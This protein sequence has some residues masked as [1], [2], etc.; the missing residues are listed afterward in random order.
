MSVGES[1][2]GTTQRG[3]SLVE[4]ALSIAILSILL[5]ALF[6]MFTQGMYVLS[7]SKEVDLA[8]ERAHDCMETVRALGVGSIVP[9]TY[10]SRNG[11]P[12]ASGFPP[13]PYNPV[14][15]QYP[16]VV[17]ATSVGAPAGTISVKIDVY[18]DQDRKVSLETYFSL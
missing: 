3:F 10:D 5:L 17:E 11:D 15:D 2:R 16:M 7:H 14:P 18:Y 4:V 6:A 1:L 12:P 9:G 13:A 8:T